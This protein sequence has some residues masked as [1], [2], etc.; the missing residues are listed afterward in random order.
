MASD[1]QVAAVIYGLSIFN[2]SGDEN[3]VDPIQ[4]RADG[5]R[6]DNGTSDNSALDDTIT[7]VLDQSG[8]SFAGGYLALDRDV[9]ELPNTYSGKIITGFAVFD[10]LLMFLILVFLSFVED[11]RISKEVINVTHS[12]GKV[13]LCA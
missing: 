9:P 8:I 1:A 12:N 7:S 3:A 4:P 6:F 13:G 5:Q 10:I 2:L 11:R